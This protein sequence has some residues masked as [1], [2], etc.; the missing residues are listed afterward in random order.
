MCSYATATTDLSGGRQVAF[1]VLLRIITAD[2]AKETKM[3]R[4]KQ[5][6]I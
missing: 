5:L 2:A 6:G 1:Y 3:Q 4:Q